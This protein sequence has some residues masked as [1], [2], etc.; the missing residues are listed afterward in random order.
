MLGQLFRGSCS[1][2]RQ[3]EP[4]KGVADLCESGFEE[5]YLGVQGPG[6]VRRQC[7][8]S[9]WQMRLAGSE[10]EMEER[11]G[12]ETPLFIHLSMSVGISLASGP[13]PVRETLPIWGGDRTMQRAMMNQEAH[14]TQA[15]AC[16]G[17]LPGGG[18]RRAASQEEVQA[19]VCRDGV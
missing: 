3:G 12:L 8:W 10:L 14:W 1:V 19:C 13:V 4:P 7:P 5:G 9:R 15:G 16:Q 11:E 17:R 2:P 18:W 6:A